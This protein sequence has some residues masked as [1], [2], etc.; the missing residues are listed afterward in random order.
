MKKLQEVC[1]EL[2]HIHMNDVDESLLSLQS[3]GL[4]DLDFS[5][6][7]VSVSIT[8]LGSDVRQSLAG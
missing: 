6:Y 4:V 5:T 3:K 8:E 7:P 2:Y 1:P